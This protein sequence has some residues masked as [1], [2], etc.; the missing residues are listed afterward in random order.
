MRNKNAGKAP[1]YDKRGMSKASRDK[2][3]AYDKKFSSSPE[4]RKKR[5]ECNKKRAEAKKKGKN[6]I[7][8]DFDHATGTFVKS[9]TNRGRKEKSRLKGAKKRK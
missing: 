4:Q 8:K 1:S 6:I 5:A 7:G 3:K 2:K 9:S